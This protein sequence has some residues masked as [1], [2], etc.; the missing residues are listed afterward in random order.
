MRLHVILNI[1]SKSF[2]I[3]FLWGGGVS[4]LNVLLISSFNSPQV[5]LISKGLS[6]V[7]IIYLRSP[8]PVPDLS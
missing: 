1:T 5:V 4:F 7:E 8:I 6:E 2:K 3:M